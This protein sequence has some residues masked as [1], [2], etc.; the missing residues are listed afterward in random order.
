MNRMLIALCLFGL[1]AVA[2]ARPGGHR[3]GHK[4][5]KGSHEKGGDKRGKDLVCAVTSE[6]YS[7]T[8][9]CTEGECSLG[10][11]ISTD[12]D[13][14]QVSTKFCDAVNENGTSLVARKACLITDME[15]NVL[16]NKTRPDCKK[17]DDDVD[18][19]VVECILEMEILFENEAAK[20]FFPNGTK[21]GRRGGRRGDSSEEDS[22][23]E[24]SSEEDEEVFGPEA[25]VAGQQE[26]NGR[27]PNKGGRQG[28][29][30][31]SEESSE[32][33]SDEQEEGEGPIVVEALEQESSESR[34]G[35]SRRRKGGKRQ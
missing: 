16:V 4:G 20:A 23:E 24:E 17:D 32:E 33:D 12:R 22:S 31:S 7:M 8:R 21:G 28:R 26:G 30:D 3:G 15:G 6:T 19:P 35:P 27:K 14:N 11:L 5:K 9:T 10:P 13:G 2:F 18:R 25:L 34:R 29:P 1:V